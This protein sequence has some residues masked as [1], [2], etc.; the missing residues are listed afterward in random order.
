MPFLAFLRPR[1]FLRALLVAMTLFALF[2][3]YHLNWIR[4]RRIA[5]EASYGHNT[6]AVDRAPLSLVEDWQGVGNQSDKMLE[7]ARREMPLM[8][9]LLGARPYPIVAVWDSESKGAEEQQ[10]RLQAL[11]PEADV[12]IFGF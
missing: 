5:F 3:G 9:R 8:L 6:P 4:Q 11:F 12:L 1:F 7:G 2:L 10:R